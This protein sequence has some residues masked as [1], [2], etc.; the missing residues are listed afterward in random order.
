[1]AAPITNPSIAT[2]AL[3]SLSSA[4]GMSAAQD[5]QHTSTAGGLSFADFLKGAAKNAATTLRANEKTTMQS[6][7]GTND[8]IL[9]MTAADN[10]EVTLQTIIAIRD[11]TVQAYQEIARMPI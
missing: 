7:S 9:T 6:A 10:A 5:H 2:Q 4:L 3:T 8:L 1:M 11:R